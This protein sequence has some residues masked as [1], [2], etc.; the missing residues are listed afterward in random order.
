MS[1]MGITEL[2]FGRVITYDPNTQ[3]PYVGFVYTVGFT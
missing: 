2:A 3:N 1:L